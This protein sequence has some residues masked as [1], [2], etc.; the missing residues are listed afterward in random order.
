MSTTKVAVEAAIQNNITI[1]FTLGPAQGAG[2]PVSPDDVDQVGMLTELLLGHTFI[3]PGGSFSGSLPPPNITPFLDHDGIIRS[4]N[5][6]INTLVAVVGA[7][8]V[9]G[10]DTTTAKRVT[11]DVDSIVDLTNEVHGTGS[12]A[13]ISWTP[14]NSNLTSALIIFYYHRN[15][16]P[17]AV[18]GFN[19][20][21]PNKPGSWGSFVVDHF[22]ASGAEVSSKFIQNNI[23][24]REGIGEMLA[25]PGVGAYM[26]EDSVEFRGQVWWSDVLADRFLERHG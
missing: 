9:D 20:A 6:T 22:S 11:L 25:R 19:G 8:V 2:I 1:D 4:A 21:Q 3:K 17:E 10:I 23:L 12:N 7:K 13:S 18:G 26:W 15:G 5:T 24:S 16:F 14:S